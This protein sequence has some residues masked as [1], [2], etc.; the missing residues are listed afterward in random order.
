V[1]NQLLSIR[2]LSETVKQAATSSVAQM[3]FAA[4]HKRQQITKLEANEPVESLR[5]RLC[6]A[7]GERPL[8]YRVTLIVALWL[9][10]SLFAPGNHKVKERTNGRAEW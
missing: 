1:K 8:K 10:G 5:D 6:V 4:S 9:E 2:N 7:L 3:E